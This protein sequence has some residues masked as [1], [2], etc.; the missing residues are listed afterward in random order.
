MTDPRDCAEGGEP[1][2]RVGI[3]RRDLLGGAAGF[4]VLGV[5]SGRSALATPAVPAVARQ[6]SPRPNIL[7]INTHDISPD[8]GCYKGVCP[9]AEYAYTP[10]LDRLAAE[11]ARF[12]HA[13][14]VCP[15]CAPSRSSAITGMWPPA[16]RYWRLY[17]GPFAPPSR[18]PIWFRAQRLGFDASP[19]VEWTGT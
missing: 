9:G 13:F 5:L 2:K 4:T 3:R 6:S 19:D 15:V 16:I 8:L 10:N 7:W 18:G 1:D 12:D 14:A 17:T 11:G